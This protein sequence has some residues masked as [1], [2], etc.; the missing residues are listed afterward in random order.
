[1]Q[2]QLEP[3]LDDGLAYEEVEV[4]T[5]P[6]KVRASVILYIVSTLHLFGGVFIPLLEIIS[7]VTPRPDTFIEMVEWNPFS[8][9][10]AIVFTYGLFL[11][12]LGIMVDRRD[13]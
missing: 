6:S 13:A 12:L 9:L 4:T 8:Q 5:Q 3:E 2:K 7:R 1:M 10:G 11:F